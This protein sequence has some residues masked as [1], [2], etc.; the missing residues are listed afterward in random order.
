V[1][2]IPQAQ[3]RRLETGDNTPL[4]VTTTCELAKC[5][6]EKEEIEVMNEKTE[7][8]AQVG[9]TQTSDATHSISCAAFQD[10]KYIE[11]I[12]IWPNY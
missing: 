7:S 10:H 4:D 3:R 1:R 12:T 5:V 11:Y 2:P 6:R 9:R 8:C